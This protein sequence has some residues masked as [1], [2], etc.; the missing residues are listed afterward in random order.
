MRIIE[1]HCHLDYLKK[2]GLD[3]VLE[4]AKVAGVQK[5][6]TI[7]VEPSNLDAPFELANTHDHIYCTQGVHPHHAKDYNLDAEIKIIKR[8]K[9]NKNVVAI[10]E[11]GLDYHYDNSP[12]EIQREV[13]EKQLQ[14]ACNLNLPVVIH[15]REAEEDTKAILSN[16]SSKLLKKGVLHSFTSKKELAEYALSENFSLGFNGIITFKNATAV[17]EVVELTPI[18]N[19]LIE[20]DAPFLTPAPHR[21]KENSP[22]YLPYILE[23]VAE[24][25]GMEVEKLAEEIYQNSLRLF[26]L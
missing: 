25:K 19:I 6:I 14:I 1:T 24:I 12:R 5:I 15:T 20:T 18:S 26:N 11:I 13:F 17:R 16:F 2:I 8:A 9:E 3:E 4:K 23:K 21:G 7:S 22:H 10:G